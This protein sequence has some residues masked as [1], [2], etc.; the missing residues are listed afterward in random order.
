MLMRRLRGDFRVVCAALLSVALLTA[1]AGSVDP[2]ALEQFRIRAQEYAKLHRSVESKVPAAP[3]KAT[4]DQIAAHQQSLSA[5][6]RQTRANANPGD[7]FGSAADSIR[8]LIAAEMKGPDGADAKKTMKD[9][10]PADEPTGGP[11]V[12]SVN[13]PY[14]PMAP[15]SSMPPK[16]LLRLP[17]LPEELNYRFVGR[18]LILLDTHADLIVDFIVNAAL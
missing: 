17:P 10:N 2:G 8:T 11:I 7:I 3:K 12:V 1:R 5:A 6:I 9:G 15:V 18:H 14:P 16:L 13:G 4:P